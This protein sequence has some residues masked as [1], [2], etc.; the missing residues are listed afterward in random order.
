MKIKLFNHLN[1][2]SFILVL[3][4]GWIDIIGLNICISDRTSFMSA[5]ASII[6]ESL[7]NGNMNQILLLTIL[8]ISFILGSYIGA[9][10]TLKKGCKYGLLLTSTILIITSFIIVYTGGVNS[11]SFIVTILVP[12]AMGCMNSSTSLT[13]ISRTT[14][15]TGP[16]TD[17]GISLA[18]GDY[19]NVVFL[20][21]RWISF[22]LGAFLGLLSL[23][24]V[25]KE[26][27]PLYLILLI[28]SILIG[29]TAILF[30]KYLS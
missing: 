26:L 30:E 5:K 23:K 6:G 16:T 24:L 20:S 15:L 21:L 14:H 11:K 13:K 9:K 2:I 28:P 22:P 10:T 12:L 19:N 4:A 7:L 27:L 1:L 17:I 3:C 29:I 18:K 25:Y 8:V